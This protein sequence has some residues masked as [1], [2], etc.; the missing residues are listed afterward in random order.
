MNDFFLANNRSITV[1]VLDT[2]VEVKQ[3]QMSD[4]DMWI[5]HAETLKEFLKN[6]HSDE[7]LTQ[8]IKVHP[9]PLMATIEHLT[10]LT[11]ASLINIGTKNSAELLKLI[12]TA[13]T[14]NGVYFKYKKKKGNANQSKD[15]STWFDSFQLLI[16]AGHTH[17]EIMKM[18]YGTFDAYSRA[19]F[20]EQKNKMSQ[21]RFAHHADA[22]SFAKHVDG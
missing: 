21:N 6:D 9:V 17:S 3:F 4:L 2:P 11:G 8:L 10:G 18:S 14:V 7:T 22:K 19:V 20:R 1:P 15:K 5:G 12:R 16:G 13:I